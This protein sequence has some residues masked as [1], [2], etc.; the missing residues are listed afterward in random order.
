KLALLLAAID[1]HIGGVIILGHRGTGKSTA[2]RAL[3]DLLPPLE[4]VKGCLFGCDP[5][6]RQDAPRPRQ[7]A[8]RPGQDSPRTRRDARHDARRHDLCHDCAAR[9]ASGARLTRQKAPVPVV[10]LPLGATEDR[11][12]G[13]LDIEQ[14]LVQGQKAFEPGLLARA[15]RGFLYI[16][17]V[18][19]LE[20]H[21]VDVL[22]D[23]SASGRNIVEREGISVS[24][25]AQ[26]VLVGSGNPE[27][28]DLR[29]QLLDRFGLFTQIETIADIKQ[30]VEIVQRRERFERSPSQ[31]ASEFLAEQESL[32][33]KLVRARKLLP[34]TRL[35]HDLLEKIAELCITLKVDGH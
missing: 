3:A 15:N 22:L 23:A 4:K 30:R 9:V 20:D 8:M 7:D 12:C 35:D 26:F 28:G 11:V 14:A 27:E 10:D 25:P 13:T 19:L 5:G 29:P 2:V 32:R 34:K 24:H 16:D 21:L 1:P 31:F 33:K 6:P 17:E 18:N